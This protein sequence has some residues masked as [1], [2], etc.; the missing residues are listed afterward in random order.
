MG[1]G[2]WKG[3]EGKDASHTSLGIAGYGLDQD[4]THVS[5]RGT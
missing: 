5:H 3:A 4:I 2:E 1:G